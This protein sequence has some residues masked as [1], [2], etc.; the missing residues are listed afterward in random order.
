M[1][2]WLFALLFRPDIVKFSL[3]GEAVERRE[4][5]AEHREQGAAQH[6]APASSRPLTTGNGL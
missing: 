5:A 6:A 1:I 4:A 3:D 2:D